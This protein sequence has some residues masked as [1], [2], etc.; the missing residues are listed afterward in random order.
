MVVQAVPV[1]LGAVLLGQGGPG[2]D[3]L[4]ADGGDLRVDGRD[5]EPVGAEFGGYTAFQSSAPSLGSISQS[6]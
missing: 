3:E 4:V 6:G 2:G 5:G 1:G